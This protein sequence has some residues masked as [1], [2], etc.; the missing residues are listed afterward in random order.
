MSVQR[1][2]PRGR[3]ARDEEFDLEEQE[4]DVRTY[5]NRIVRYWWLPA[6]GLIIGLL[7]GLLLAA[8]GKK[9][10]K[11]EATLYLGQAFTPNG[12]AQVTSLGTN[13]ATVNQ[14]VHS[15][16]VIERAAQ[17]SGMKASQIRDGV[18]S[19]IVSGS[20]GRRVAPGTQPLVL[21]SVKGPNQARVERAT[22]AIARQ[23]ITRVGVYVNTKVDNLEAQQATKAQELE[24]IEKK[25]QAASDALA[26]AQRQNR[27]A[28]DRL[29]LTSIL[30]NAEQRRAAVEGELLDVRQLLN[31][32]NQVEKPQIFFPAEAVETTAR[33]KRNSM[34]AGALLGLLLGTV[35]A[36]LWEPVAERRRKR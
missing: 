16:F 31:L 22:N 13:P 5:W 21:I 2:A 1:E 14:T 27:D 34:L 30:D 9:V 4:V 20:A 6:A 24:S 12:T 29:V 33:S 26:A 23:T 18:T 19:R 36:L 3:R 11:A 28:L 8:G 32:A 17:R 15:E 7:L 25:V 35:A 10:Y